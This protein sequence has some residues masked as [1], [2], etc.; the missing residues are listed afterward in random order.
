LKVSADNLP[1]VEKSW[2]LY[3]PDSNLGRKRGVAR[4]LHERRVGAGCA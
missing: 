3:I 2:S 1:V 4:A